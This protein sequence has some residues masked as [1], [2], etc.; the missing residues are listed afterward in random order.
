MTITSAHQLF[1]PAKGNIIPHSWYHH[2][3]SAKGTP[4][5][6]AINLLSEIYYWYRPKENGENKFYSDILQL[7]Y[8]ELEEKLNVKKEAIRRAFVRLEEKGLVKR[9][10]RQVVKRGICCSNVLFVHLNKEKLALITPEIQAISSNTL[11]KN[12][13]TKTPISI[14][15]SNEEER[16]P[17]VRGDVYKDFLK[18]KSLAL[19]NKFLE[20]E[21]LNSNKQNSIYWGNDEFKQKSVLSFLPITESF[22][23]KI[24]NTLHTNLPKEYFEELITI[25]YQ[26]DKTETENPTCSERQLLARIKGWTKTEKRSEQNLKEIYGIIPR[27]KQHQ[28]TESILSKYENSTDISKIAIIKRKIAGELSKEMAV[29]LLTNAYIRLSDN[30]AN[31]KIL[32]KNSEYSKDDVYNSI[33]PIIT[34][35]LGERVKIN[36]SYSN[37]LKPSDNIGIILPEDPLHKT[38]GQGIIDKYGTGIYKSWFA[39]I[40]ITQQDQSLYIITDNDFK[41]NYLQNNYLNS[42]NAILNRA[43]QGGLNVMVNSV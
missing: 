40:K 14:D 31:I 32:D 17:L 16:S 1:V 21:N 30:I 8:S 10:L 20:K 37:K 7:K 2:L 13:D 42:I 9:E 35:I 33:N 12:L 41:S 3:L 5:Y 11:A 26:K 22:F 18:D 25:L 28:H 27:E 34:N 24:N 43:G 19:K 4:D 15:N 23:S 39:D 38:I 36:I 6:T 29:F